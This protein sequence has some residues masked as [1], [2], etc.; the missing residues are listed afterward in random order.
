MLH[1]KCWNSKSRICYVTTS[2]GSWLKFY[3]AAFSPR[4]KFVLLLFW[5][6]SRGSAFIVVTGLRVGFDYRQG[7]QMYIL[8]LA[9]RPV[10]DPTSPHLI[11]T[12]YGGRVMKLTFHLYLVPS[13]RIC[14]AV[15]PFFHVVSWHSRG[16]RCVLLNLFCGL[17]LLECVFL[18]CIL[19]VQML[20]DIHRHT[21]CDVFYY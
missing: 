13:L 9:P 14:G 21:R 12:G 5:T 1:L 15:P 3:L 19:F 20:Y 18:W 11:C 4:P 7:Q 17:W 8:T 2:S 6:R 16:Q 10:W